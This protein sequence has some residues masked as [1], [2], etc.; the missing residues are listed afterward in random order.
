MASWWDAIV[1]FF[2][3]KDVAILGPRSAGKTTLYDFLQYRTVVSKTPRTA[4]IAPTRRGIVRHT[5]FSLSF[6]K[7]ADVPGKETNYSDWRQLLEKADVV[8]YVFDAHKARTDH[9]YAARISQDGKVL[10]SWGV[11]DKAVYLIGTHRDKDPLSLKCSAAE[12]ADTIRELDVIE[13]LKSR[14]RARQVGVGDLATNRS[15]GSLLRQV[16][17]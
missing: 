12:Y 11:T 17:G 15:A 10:K 6:H 8:F 7:G 3:G 4:T 1:V 5:G 16:V 9:S 14:L 2:T 13:A